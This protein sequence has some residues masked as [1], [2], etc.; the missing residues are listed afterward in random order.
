MDVLGTVI[1]I[2]SPIIAPVIIPFRKRLI[3][4]PLID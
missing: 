1:Y 4:A 2:Y 3:A